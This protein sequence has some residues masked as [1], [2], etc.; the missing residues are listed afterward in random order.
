[1]FL[2]KLLRDSLNFSRRDCLRRHANEGNRC[3]TTDLKKPSDWRCKLGVDMLTFGNNMDYDEQ[4]AQKAVAII[5]RLIAEGT[6]SRERIDESY[7]RILALKMR[8]K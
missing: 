8:L 1:M 3:P 2:T 6:I 5:K 4:I 7:R